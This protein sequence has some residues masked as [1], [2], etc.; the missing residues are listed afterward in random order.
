MGAFTAPCQPRCLLAADA[1]V[2]FLNSD[3][4]PTLQGI[5][6]SGKGVTAK[7]CP[8]CAKMNRT[9]GTPGQWQ[10][11]QYV[12][13]E[14]FCPGIIFQT[15]HRDTFGYPYHRRNSTSWIKTGH[16]DRNG[17][18]KSRITIWNIKECTV[19]PCVPFKKLQVEA[20]SAS[21]A[22]TQRNRLTK[23]R[24]KKKTK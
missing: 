15:G 9:H 13:E 4:R 11:F 6:R 8:P 21:A 5:T 18:E 12:G 20:V 7:K 16:R 17:T 14:Y 2:P 3:S 10:T 24:R 19:V 22:M 1:G 23:L